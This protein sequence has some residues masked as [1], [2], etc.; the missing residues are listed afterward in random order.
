MTFT[1]D[2]LTNIL[3][4]RL[5][6]PETELPDDSDTPFTDLGLDSLAVVEVQIGVEHRCGVEVPAEDAHHFTTPQSVV[7]YV[8]HRLSVT[9][10]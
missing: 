7:D 4:E 1:R 8:N 5:G 10:S 2:D 9:R 3:V 6:F